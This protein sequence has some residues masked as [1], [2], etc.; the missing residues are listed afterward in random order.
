MEAVPGKLAARVAAPVGFLALADEQEHE[1]HE[2]DA[3]QPEQRARG[4]R[5]RP[6]L[7]ARR[8]TTP[9]TSESAA[10]IRATGFSGGMARMPGRSRTRISRPHHA[11]PG[12]DEGHRVPCLIGRSG[13]GGKAGATG[14]EPATSAVTG[15][16]S[17]Q[18]SYA[19]AI[20]RGAPGALARSLSMPRLA[21][22][23]GLGAPQCRAHAPARTGQPASAC[24]RL[25]ARGARR[26]P[27]DAR[28]NPFSV[29]LEDLRD[30][31]SA[32]VPFPPGETR[33]SLPRTRRFAE[34]TAADAARVPTS[35]T[36]RSSRCGC[37]TAT[38]CSCSGPEANHYMLVSHASNFLWRDGHFRDLIG[39][40]GDGLLTIDGDFHRRSRRIM[41]PA[42]HREHI[43]ASVD[44]IVE[45]T[46]RALDAAAAGRERRPVRVDAPP[47]ACAWRCA[48]CSASTPTARAPA[49]STPPGCSRRRSPSTRSDYFL[50]VLRGARSP[51]ARMQRAARKLDALIYAEIAER[52]ATGR[53][54]RRTSSACC[55]TR[56]T[57]T[58]TRSATCRS[59][60]R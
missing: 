42:F 25:A 16:R 52:R 38:S 54:R 39:L 5:A 31:R 22:A 53:A 18:L 37:S 51:W 35:A 29:L 4:R 45:E 9:A 1:R 59:A 20:A 57:R 2:R 40:M 41:L 46:E 43:A 10:T 55:S 50:R 30:E 14:L 27:A 34:R 60:T 44:A 24:A 12:V 21:P 6:W 49:R 36:A 23:A 26:P 28:R 56:T 13:R 8:A 48:R 33:F 7:E 58:A 15:Q 3:G 32:D 19:P 17:N 11:G 47:G